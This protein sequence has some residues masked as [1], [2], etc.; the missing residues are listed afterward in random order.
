MRFL[1]VLLILVASPSIAQDA[2]GPCQKESAAATVTPNVA[3]GVALGICLAG[4]GKTS[5]PAPAQQPPLKFQYTPHSGTLE[6]YVPPSIW[7]DNGVI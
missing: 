5:A 3:N 6:T 1:A 7:G 4:A 2:V